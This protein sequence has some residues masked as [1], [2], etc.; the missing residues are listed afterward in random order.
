[1]NCK[2]SIG[3]IYQQQQQFF[4][5]QGAYRQAVVARAFHNIN[6]V[7]NFIR[8][9]IKGDRQVC[10]IDILDNGCD[11]TG[12]QL[13]L[14]AESTTGRVVGTNIYPGFPQQTV[15]HRCANNEFYLM[16]GQRLTF[17]PATFDLVISF[18][19]LEH[20]P[21]PSQYLQECW[22]VMRPGGYG[23]FSWYPLW[24]GA[25]GH[26]IHHDMVKQNAQRL[27]VTPPV[28]SLDGTAIPF[29]GHLLFSPQEMLDFLGDRLRYPASLA[30]WMRDYIYD[31]PDLNRWFW[32]DV[33]RSFQALDW[34]ILEVKHC[35]EQHPDL[36]T[37]RQLKQ[38]YGTVD[39]FQI[40]GAT[41][42]VQKV[43]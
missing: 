34:A 35:G 9:R 37:L 33:W 41:V 4:A 15:K 27:G 36:Q 1:P 31:E 12:R 20:V 10:N 28:Y 16:D 21:N 26:H 39:H 42:I 19:V 22:R 24:S 14:L 6:Q 43:S 5:A 18:N 25:T 23:F 38:K 2:V 29:W 11:P 30:R 17:A 13:A 32:R 3:D 8:Q 7:V 40:C